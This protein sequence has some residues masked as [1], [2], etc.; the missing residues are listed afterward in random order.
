MPL[1]TEKLCQLLHASYHS[2]AGACHNFSED[3]VRMKLGLAASDADG[4][5]YQR[6]YGKACDDSD[7]V[8]VAI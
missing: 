1:R 5:E 2:D 4:A 8:T 3:S 6:G 7:E